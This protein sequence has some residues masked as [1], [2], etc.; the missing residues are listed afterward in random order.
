L[1]AAHSEEVEKYKKSGAAVTQ[2]FFMDP[3]A[4]NIYSWI[5]WV[6]EKNLP[7][8]WVEDKTTRHYSNLKDICT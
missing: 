6:V 7:F 8:N 2:S 4:K 5:D 3:K 1:R